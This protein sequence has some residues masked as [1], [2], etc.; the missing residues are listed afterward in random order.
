M[1]DSVNVI[2]DQPAL[3]VEGE[4]RIMI[5]REGATLIVRYGDLQIG[6]LYYYENDQGDPIR[7]KVIDIGGTPVGNAEIGTE[8]VA[9][10]RKKVF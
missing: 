3:I 10:L 7:Y 4:R 2:I 9:R 6:D 5:E 1:E 8:I